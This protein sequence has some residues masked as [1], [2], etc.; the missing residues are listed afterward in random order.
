MEDFYF[1]QDRKVTC[2]ERDF[3][4]VQAESY[5]EAVAIVKARYGAE[6]TEETDGRIQ[7]EECRA[8]CE[9]AED[10]TPEENGGCPTLE[11]FDDDGNFIMSNASSPLLDGDET[12]A[13][14]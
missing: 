6:R 5:E 14:K 11:V 12:A 10:L 3:F 1:Y 9:T 13:D 2:W 4:T 7:F 8:L